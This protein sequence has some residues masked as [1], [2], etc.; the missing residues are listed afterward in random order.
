MYQVWFMFGVWWWIPYNA[1]SVL[2]STRECQSLSTWDF[3]QVLNYGA[4]TRD[5]FLSSRWWEVHPS[6]L[7]WTGNFS[8]YITVDINI[9]GIHF[10]FM[11]HPRTASRIVAMLMWV[12][13]FC[14]ETPA[15]LDWFGWG[16][17]EHLDIVAA[18]EFFV[19][20]A[21]S[22][23]QPSVGFGWRYP[24][25]IPKVPMFKEEHATVAKLS[26]LGIAMQVRWGTLLDSL[27]HLESRWLT[28]AQL[29]CIGLRSPP[30][31]GE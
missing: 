19:T 1:F 15:L 16:S 26:A 21:S 28:I 10:E 14:I 4:E 8:E 20:N 3:L 11:R 13:L 31:A 24:Q 6:L 23:G 30:F 29:P 12:L 9:S 27:Y 2:F 18:T 5:S 25:L 17:Y 7:C 22:W